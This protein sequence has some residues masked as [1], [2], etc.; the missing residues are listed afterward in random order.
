MTVL[1]IIIGL[2]LGAE[3]RNF[4]RSFSRFVT[5]SVDARLVKLVPND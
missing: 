1:G 3:Y 2:I 5:L 4:K